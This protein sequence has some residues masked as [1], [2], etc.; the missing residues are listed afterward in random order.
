MKDE[1]RS[2]TWHEVD[3]GDRSTNAGSGSRGGALVRLIAPLVV[4]LLLFLAD[5]PV[6]AAIVGIAGLALGVATLLDPAVGRRVTGF[7]ARFAHVVGR[8]LTVVLLGATFL[9][10]FVPIGLISRI[11]HRPLRASRGT[12]PAGWLLDLTL[13]ER[14]LPSRPFSRLPPPTV[15]RRPV[16]SLALAAVV[17]VAL[18]LAV[19]SALGGVTEGETALAQSQ[20]E[21]VQSW[22]GL[23]AMSGSPWAADYVDDQITSLSTELPYVPFQVWQAADVST[24]YIN[25]TD[26]ERRSYEPPVSGDTR[27]MRVAFFGGSAM[28]GFG[29]RDTHTIASEV[30]RVAEE[31]G[32]ALEV[33]NYSA[34]GWVT[35]QEYLMFDRLQASGRTFDLAVFF[36]GFNDHSVQGQQYS[37][38][39]P[40]HYG[41]DVLDAGTRQWYEA[42]YEQPGPIDHLRDLA[43]SWARASAVGQLVWPSRGPSLDSNGRAAGSQPQPTATPAERDAATAAVFARTMDNVDVTARQAGIP[44]LSFW[45]PV[46][47]GWQQDLLDRLPP[48]TSLLLAV[49]GLPDDVYLDDVHFNE[50]G[51][52]LE[53]EAMWPSIRAALPQR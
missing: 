13:A 3:A 35:W 22:I 51:A 15:G 46:K 12:A 52:R 30:A 18:D 4:S 17:L 38:Y 25:V 2:I 6:P 43:S 42:I 48:T 53:A 39:A 23:P 50:R 47:G 29:Q 37:P 10:V 24:R 36:D 20:R 28:F 8:V 14:P 27:P 49:P 1:T 33:H 40:T 31:Q 21:G 5:R 11:A 34:T 9:V 45:Q 19:G 32:V 16:A 7:F 26:G 41:I 44:T